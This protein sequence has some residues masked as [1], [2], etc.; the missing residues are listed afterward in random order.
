MRV[1]GAGGTVRDHDH[2]RGEVAGQADIPEQAF[3]AIRHFRMRKAEQ[4]AI[5]CRLVRL[6]QQMQPGLCIDLA[7]LPDTSQL[8]AGP[9]HIPGQ[10][11]G[12]A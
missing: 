5:R 10:L 11:D 2:N 7:Q 9:E 3:Q 12:V 4:P 1:V 6:P 8:G